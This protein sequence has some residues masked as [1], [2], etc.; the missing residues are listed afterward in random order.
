MDI[1]INDKKYIAVDMKVVEP[2]SI[3]T[4]CYNVF[5][6]KY[7]HVTTITCKDEIEFMYL[8]NEYLKSKN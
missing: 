7:K 2:N 8:F 3:S 5:D 6:E 4:L 1:L